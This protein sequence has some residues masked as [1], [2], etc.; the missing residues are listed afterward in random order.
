VIAIANSSSMRFYFFLSV[1]LLAAGCG[2]NA[3]TNG[4]NS[5][6]N[7]PQPS[8][9]SKSQPVA[10]FTYEIV[11]KFPHD[12]AAF[13]QGLVY[14]DGFLFEGTGGDDDNDDPFFSSIRRVELETGKVVQKHEIPREFFG[15]GITIMNDQIY[16]L[17]WKEMT[18]FV[19]DVKDFRLLREV[20]YAG[21]GWGLTND[22]THLIMSD[23]THVIRFVNPEDFKTVRTIV[24]NDENGRPVTQINELEMVKGEIWANVWQTGWIVRIDPATGKLLGRIDLNTLADDEQRKNRKADVLNGIAYDEATDRIFVTGKLWGSLFEIRVKPKQ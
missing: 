18:A 11:K 1:V 19:Y 6:G 13:T 24:V 2:G 5:A 21:Q 10:L 7:T 16:Q 4:P 9:V 17:T 15:E 8:N 12:P 23:G 22:G 14:R 20:R 3:N